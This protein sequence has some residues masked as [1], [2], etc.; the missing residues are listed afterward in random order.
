MK[1]K[2]LVLFVVA[3]QLLGP[4]V[5]AQRVTDKLTRGLVA[6]P[7]GDKTG[8]DDRY[9]MSGKGI[10]VSWRKLPKSRRR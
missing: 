6:I 1:A 4:I 10:F 9:G 3:L 7:Q 2:S 5:N 8:Q